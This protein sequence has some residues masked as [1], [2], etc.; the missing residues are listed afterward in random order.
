MGVHSL[1]EFGQALGQVGQG[2]LLELVDIL[3]VLDVLV[4]VADVVD[5][6]LR[7]VLQRLLHIFQRLVRGIQLSLR[8]K[9][10]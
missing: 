6:L 3:L 4:D 1:G 8:K 5:G 10:N 9:I 7:V 2:R